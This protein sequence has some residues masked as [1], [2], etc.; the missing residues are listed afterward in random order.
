MW[1]E[2][3]KSEKVSNRSPSHSTY[4]TYTHLR[5]WIVE[6]RAT[7]CV[8]SSQR[9]SNPLYTNVFCL[10]GCR[11]LVVYMCMVYSRQLDCFFSHSFLLFL[12]H[13]Y[14]FPW[15]CFVY[16]LFTCLYTVV[17]RKFVRLCCMHRLPVQ[18]PLVYSTLFVVESTRYG[19]L[20]ENYETF[21]FVQTTKRLNAFA[22]TV[23]GKTQ[24]HSPDL[25]HVSEL[26]WCEF[27]VETGL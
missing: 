4:N 6:V 1:R 5:V 2:D 24:T 20:H 3:T 18:R 12:V 21:F 23:H 26:S 8:H 25:F 16:V 10:S 14:I 9:K 11:M 15:F 19:L 7:T 22:S 17:A 27:F 13:S